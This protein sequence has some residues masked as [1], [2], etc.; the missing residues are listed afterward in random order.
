MLKKK[1]KKKKI[2]YQLWKSV[3][4]LKRKRRQKM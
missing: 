3:S 2:P 1:R 4:D